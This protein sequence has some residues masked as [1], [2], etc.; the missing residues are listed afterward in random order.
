MPSHLWFQRLLMG[1]TILQDYAELGK[2]SEVMS[3]Y[4][5]VHSGRQK[6]EAIW[7]KKHPNDSLKG[8]TQGARQGFDLERAVSHQVHAGS[9]VAQR[10][11]A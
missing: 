10:S 7:L 2:N 4:G 3:I 6:I 5:H 11:H 9:L 1:R 8:L